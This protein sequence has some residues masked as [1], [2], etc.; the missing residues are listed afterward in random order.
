MAVDPWHKYW[1]EAEIASWNIYD[2]FKLKKNP[3]VSMAYI[4]YLSASTVIIHY[5]VL[6]NESGWRISKEQRVK[7][8]FHKFK[9]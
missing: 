7:S 6:P 5:G 8:Y 3:L 4:K 9:P 2:D 1:N